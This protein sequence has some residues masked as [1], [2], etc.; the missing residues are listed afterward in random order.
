MSFGHFARVFLCVLLCVAGSQA[1]AQEKSA[2]K[3]GFSLQ[4]G[5][6]K[7]LLF[8][9]KISVGSQSTGG[10]REPNADWT[11]QARDNIG[12]ALA[13]AQKKLG[14]EVVVVEEPVGPQVDRL[15]AY[16]GLFGI[17]AQS[18]IEFKFFP[19]NRLP[20]KKREGVFDWTL[21]PGVADLAA[22]TGCRYGLFILTD[23]EFG[24]TGRKLFQLFAAMGGVGITSGV[25]KG[26]AG[27]VDLTTGDLVWLNADLQMGGDVR[28]ADG[29]EKR[30]AQL[31]EDFPGRVT[32][33]AALRP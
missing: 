20:S 10:M 2:I 26:F 9:P 6:T 5:S 25:H 17:V 18:V 7:I 32:E 29:A 1:F 15:A 22:G 30:V 27:L 13:A 33:V 28:A 8:R 23:D 21:G 12:V 3:S 31:L 14:N 24:S 19:G 4:P 11:A 16:Q